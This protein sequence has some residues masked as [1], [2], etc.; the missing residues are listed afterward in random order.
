MIK[1]HKNCIFVDFKL[2]VLTSWYY[3][4]HKFDLNM[5]NCTNNMSESWKQT[6]LGTKSPNQSNLMQLKKISRLHVQQI[7]GIMKSPWIR[8]DMS[9]GIRTYHVCYALNYNIDRGG[10]LGGQVRGLTY[11]VYTGG[12]QGVRSFRSY[13]LY[14]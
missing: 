1:T 7:F 13:L 6:W 9:Y 8:I 10:Y 4:N 12:G 2:S 14:R 11:G 5:D 3:W